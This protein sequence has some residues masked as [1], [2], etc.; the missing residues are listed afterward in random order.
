MTWR[1]V[2][3][4]PAVGSIPVCSVKA[5]SREAASKSK[6][7]AAT[8]PI[9]VIVNVPPARE[10]WN[11][12]P[13]PA[14]PPKVLPAVRVMVVESGFVPFKNPMMSV[15]RACGVFVPGIIGSVSTT[16]VMLLVSVKLANGSI[17]TLVV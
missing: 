3:V 6:F 2:S 1:N 16:E 15:E 10:I 11:C 14:I 17:T 8:A 13:S 12:E 5:T 7:V 4:P 9:E